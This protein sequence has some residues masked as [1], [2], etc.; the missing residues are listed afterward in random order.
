MAREIADMHAADDRRDVMLAM[1]LEADIAQHHDLVVAAGL[2][3]GAL[4]IFARIV[5]VA[6]EPFLV[7]ARYAR[8][9]GAQPLAVGIVAGPAD[10]RTDRGLGLG[11]RRPGRPRRLGSRAFGTR[12][13]SHSVISGRDPY[14]NLVDW[15]KWMGRNRQAQ[16]DVNKA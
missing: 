9:R 14:T 11:A 3:E 13:F 1:G 4:E 8:R 10:Q 15:T 2:L 16:G 12:H 6:G 5:V 7:G